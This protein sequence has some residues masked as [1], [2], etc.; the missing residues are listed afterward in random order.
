MTPDQSAIG[1]NLVSRIGNKP[2]ATASLNLLRNNNLTNLENDSRYPLGVLRIGN[3]SVRVKPGQ[4][5][6]QINPH[7]IG[8][9]AE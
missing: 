7:G 9:T 1:L 5:D 4:Q 8:G 2:P 3:I 6:F